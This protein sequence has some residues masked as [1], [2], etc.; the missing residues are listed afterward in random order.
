MIPVAVIC[1]FPQLPRVTVPPYDCRL[2]VNSAL[3]CTPGA[4]WWV[5]G[6]QRTLCRISARPSIGVLT[7]RHEMEAR[8]DDPAWSGQRFHAWQD[9]GLWDEHRKGRPLQWGVQA[10]LLLAA[11]LSPEVH[12]WETILQHEPSTRED[13]NGY[14]GTFRSEERWNKE[15]ADLLFTIS[16]LERHNINVTRPEI[17]ME[18]P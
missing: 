2:V 18:S 8:E 13:C 9:L 15:R 16:L 11:E 7:M 10:A 12:L 17:P 1:P 4:E 6:D 3:S 14:P 5:A